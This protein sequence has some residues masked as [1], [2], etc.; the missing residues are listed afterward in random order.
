MAYAIGISPADAYIQFTPGA[1]VVIDYS[2]RSYRP[3]EFYTEGPFSEFTR[4]E[5]ISHTDSDGI[6]RIYIRMPEEYHEPGK[7]RMYVVAKEKSSPGVVNTIAAIRGF[8]EFDVP[9]PGFYAELSV[10]VNDV[11]EGEPVVLFVNV[12]NRGK[13]AI[14]DAVVNIDIMA[15]GKTVKTMKSEAFS[16]EPTAGHSFTEVI[17]GGELKPG[18]YE[19]VA[20]LDY[21]GKTAEKT[22]T[23]KVGTFD[24]AII[25][26]TTQMY[27]NSVN[28]F[29]IE[30]ASLW[31]NRMNKVF[32]DLAIMEN[33][34]SEKVLSSVTTPPFDLKQW[35]R[36]KSSFY[37]NTQDVPVGE[38]PLRITLHYDDGTKV[39]NRKIYIVEKVIPVLET[40][41]PLT[42]V[43]LV[44]LALLL[45]LFNMYFIFFR[46]RKKK[47]EKETSAKSGNKEEKKGGGR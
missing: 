36:K 46:D 29:E 16:M 42:T 30:V 7:H 3:F 38:Y 20:R 44:A 34:N 35:E 11:N 27:N 47:E 22:K 6:F 26:Y 31:N 12:L 41:F 17:E 28:L 43:L 18:T 40:P 33:E 45:I 9:F 24:V 23:F 19:A 5:T 37:W 32:M 1:E 10:S 39:E 2:I 25:N 4:I 13:L 8:V 21:E 15:D 14:T